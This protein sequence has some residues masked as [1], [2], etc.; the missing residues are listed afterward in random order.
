MDTLQNMRVFALVVKSG[1][2]TTVALSMNSSTGAMSRAVSE[3][4]EHLR[5]RLI[6]RSTRK[7]SLTTA[8]ERYLKRCLQIL[9][10]I[11]GAEEEA[12]CAHEHPS[13][14]LR[15]FSFASIGQ[16]YVLPAIAQYRRQYSDVSVDLTLSQ[17]MPDLFERTSDVAIISATSLPDSEMVSQ[18]LGATFSILCASQEYVRLAGTLE[19]PADLAQHQCL[20]LHTPAFPANEWILDGL[21]GVQTM[22]ISGPVQVNITESLAVA[23][24]EGLGIGMLP[25]YATVE[26]LRNA[27]GAH[28]GPA[29]FAEDEYLCA[30]RVALLRRCKDANVDRLPAHLPARRDRAR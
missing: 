9:A 23:I 22:N 6:T 13:G 17:R 2:F 4:E 30:L 28:P 24:R 26:G 18:P 5:T 12:S 20:T 21:D 19:H 15:M 11:D 8:G 3:L 14:T 25:L 16:H 7:L 10:D 29:H 27:S 1:S